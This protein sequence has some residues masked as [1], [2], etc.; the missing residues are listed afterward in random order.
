MNGPD[1]GAALLAYTRLPA[2]GYSAYLGGSVHFALRTEAG[3]APLFRGYGKLF[4][5]CS[6]SRENGIVSRG[7]R[8]V[9]LC[10]AGEDYVVFGRETERAKE[11][12]GVTERE[13]GMFVRWLTADFA[14]FRG[15]FRVASPLDGIEA[16]EIETA[17]PIASGCLPEGAEAGAELPI[18]DAL[19]GNLL[20]RSA[21]VR[22]QSVELPEEAVISSP[23][24]LDAIT[25]EVR[26]TDGSVR[27]ARID[28]D[29][30]SFDGKTDF[31]ARGRIRVRRI[32][33]PAE[34]HPWGD[35]VILCRGGRYYFIATDDTDGNRSFRIREAD[36]P[37]ALFS[38]AVRSAVL[39]DAEHSR[40]GGTF[41]A[42]EFHETD[43]KLRIFCALSEKGRGFD[44]QAH[45]MTFLGGDL[46]DPSRWSE[47][48]RCVM[49][50]G[51]FLNRDPLGDGKN[52]ITLDMT[53]FAAGGIR[54]A[55]WSYRTWEGCDSGSMLMIARID[56]KEPWRLTSYPVLLSRPVYAWEHNKV[57]D[58]NEGPFAL[59]RE[60]R[61]F[62]T[63]SAGSAAEDTYA[64]GMLTAREDA[65]LCDPAAWTK[66]TT[67][68]LASGFV[69]GQYGCG[70]NAFFT[71]ES[72]DTHITYHG[73]DTLDPSPR[74]VGVRRVHFGAAGRPVLDMTDEEDLPRSAEAVSV[75]V[76]I[77]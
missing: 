71:D 66:E 3:L 70:H 30:V 20:R 7:V 2:P 76:R 52:G 23:D 63:Y 48:R 75:R 40:F 32:P 77:T 37:E 50:D 68:V 61:V 47:P 22:F 5:A 27:R 65:D 4:A 28:W 35:P 24:D 62:L 31:T 56:P 29:P 44:P 59:V 69:P 34:R 53:C 18:P 38:D 11:A 25:A 46:T 49:P 17:S 54:Y 41:W 12:G 1:R 64:V 73:H 8:S 16:E 10:R 45:V 13:T 57:T 21:R 51:R 39:L 72:G 6:F 58:N 19:A 74:L 67:P 33:F 36:S 9:S 26:Y 42:P 43:G 60:G 14:S 15:P 55:V